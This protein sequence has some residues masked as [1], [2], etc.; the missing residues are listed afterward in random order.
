[1]IYFFT[2][3]LALAGGRRSLLGLIFRILRRRHSTLLGLGS[4]ALVL[5]FKG[6]DERVVPWAASFTG[7]VKNIL[8]EKN[9]KITLMALIRA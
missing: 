3:V 6:L 1:M 8:G 5:R 2:A 7:F 4:L 9:K